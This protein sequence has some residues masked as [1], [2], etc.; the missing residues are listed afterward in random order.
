MKKVIRIRLNQLIC[1]FA[2]AVFIYLL[3]RYPSE[4]KTGA[5]DGLKAGG[6]ILIPS[7]FPFMAAALFITK[8]GIPRFVSL[9]LDKLCRLLFKNGNGAGTLLSYLAGFPVGAKLI[10][11][12]YKS[13]AL[14]KS[15]TAAKLSYS[16]NSGPAFIIT[17][18]GTGV[19]GSTELGVLLFCTVTL[20]SVI[21]GMIFTRLVSG[22]GAPQ[23]KG[24]IKSD[25]TASEAFVNSVCDTSLSMLG[26]TGFVVLFSSLLS[27]L[28]KFL[29]SGI[30]PAAAGLLEVTIGVILNRESSLPVLAG[31][32]GFGGMSVICQVLMAVK[33]VDFDRKV[34]FLSR[35]THGIL[36]FII[37]KIAISVIPIPAQT[38]LSS[39]IP[40]P[41][42]GLSVSLTGAMILMAVTL[43]FSSV[44]L[45][46]GEK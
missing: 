25:C 1:V 7:L 9:P 29:P 17:V 3:F 6:E 37:T 36:S 39:G 30:I 19:L 38:L 14:D 11:E 40:S 28:K 34:F 43:L 32:I 22:G 21:N 23:P 18:V 12:E 5:L 24:Y 27:M 35:A 41:A 15:G 8:V 33:E 42:G 45:I 44:D 16:V 4:A 31:V 20:S 10:A 26:I 2:A 13:G 46:R